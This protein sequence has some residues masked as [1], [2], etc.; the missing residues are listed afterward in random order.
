MVAAAD[1]AHLSQVGQ[2][3]VSRDG[4]GG[5]LLLQLGHG[6]DVDLAGH[7]DQHM[8][9][10]APDSHGQRLTRHRPLAAAPARH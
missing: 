3:G 10:F 8:P 7:G 2:H 1:R 9:G 5:Q 6:G 4:Q